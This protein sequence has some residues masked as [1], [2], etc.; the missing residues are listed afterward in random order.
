MARGGKIGVAAPDPLLKVVPLHPTQ[1]VRPVEA[2]DGEDTAAIG[3]RREVGPYLVHVRKGVPLVCPCRE[4]VK[5]RVK[6]HR[7]QA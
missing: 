5:K 3:D 2:S 6:S 7:G 1:H 4:V